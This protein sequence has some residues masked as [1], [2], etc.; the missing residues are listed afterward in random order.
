LFT[1]HSTTHSRRAFLQVGALDKLD[2]TITS[3]QNAILQAIAWETVSLYLHAG[4][5]KK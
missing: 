1:I 2:S 4:F 3:E 5:E